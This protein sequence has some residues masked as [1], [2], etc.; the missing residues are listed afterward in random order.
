MPR[1]S[2]APAGTP[3]TVI[4]STSEPSVSASAATIGSVIALSSFPLA[5]PTVRLGMSATAAIV[6]GRLA[7]VMPIRPM[8]VVSTACT[9]S[10]NGAAYSSVPMVHQGGGIYAGNIPAMNAFDRVRFYLQADTTDLPARNFTWPL[11]AAGGDVFTAYAQ[12]GQATLFTDNFQT[13]TGWVVSGAAATGAWTRVT[14]AA[15][16]GHGAVIGDADVAA[17]FEPLPPEEQWR[18]FDF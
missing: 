9:V 6:T 15:N 17:F 7:S 14:P 12:S 10:V 5:A 3:L 8:G 1:L 11:N 16:G 13:N 18:P 2:S 4:V